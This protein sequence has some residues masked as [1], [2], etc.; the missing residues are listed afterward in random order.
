MDDAKKKPSFLIRDILGDGASQQGYRDEPTAAAAAAGAAAGA[1]GFGA[2][3]S[4]SRLFCPTAF[5]PHQ[6]RELPSSVALSAGVSRSRRQQQQLLLD[7]Q[8][9]RVAPELLFLQTFCSQAATNFTTMLSARFPHPPPPPPPLH[10]AFLPYERP[11]R[12]AS[13]P[14]A[15]ESA[16][17]HRKCRRSRTVF[18]E[19]QLLG[20]EK[21]FEV[22]KYL[23]TPDRVDLAGVLGLNQLQVKT[24]YQNRRMK[25]K[26][27][28]LQ[29]GDVDLPTKSKGRPRRS[30]S[31]T[32]C[33][34]EGEADDSQ[35]DWK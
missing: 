23:S 7:E 20:L 30:L 28:A 27:E 35:S 12:V 26:K 31:D 19:S 6:R 32:D 15:E 24:W 10:A 34:E 16:A 9:A 14:V 25:W 17:K 13:P 33:D 21:K 4:E 22:Q 2:E 8:W 1:A 3:R 5:L 18:T 29:N 11:E